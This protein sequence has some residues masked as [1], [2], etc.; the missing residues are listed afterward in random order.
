M[1]II[2]FHGSQ[3]P[4][5]T[6]WGIFPSTLSGLDSNIQRRQQK[7]EIGEAWLFADCADFL[8]TLF[9]SKTLPP[10]C[11]ALCWVQGGLAVSPSNCRT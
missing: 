6:Q 2:L 8:P 10:L 9:I 5:Y 11:V 3:R 7:D 4:G 1:F